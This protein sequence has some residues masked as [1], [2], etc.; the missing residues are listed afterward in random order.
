MSS[1]AFP[2]NISATALLR[3][4]PFLFPV[5]FVFAAILGS[6]SVLYAA[7]ALHV[8]AI[9]AENTIGRL[10]SAVPIVPLLRAS[11][12]FEDACLVIWPIA[13]LTALVAALWLLAHAE[14]TARQVF[15][16]GAIFGYSISIFSAAAGHELL[17]GRS[18]V[19]R[20]CS[21]FLYAA[22]LYPHFPAV[23][24]ASHHRWAGST[25]DCQTPRP[26]QHIH[27][28]LIQALVGGLRTVPRPQAGALD[29]HLYARVLAATVGVTTLGLVGG[30]PAMSFHIVQGLFSFIVVETLNYVQHYKLS[31]VADRQSN[32]AN[33]DLNFVSRCA[34]FNLSLH[35]S[36]HL[37]QN[38]HYSQLS[39]ISGAPSCCWGYWTSFW[40][41]WTPPAWSHLHRLEAE[42]ED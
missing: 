6:I 20:L 12:F 14:P 19:A 2:M 18:R 13:H 9:A 39:P 41:A 1:T 7:V 29:P 27:S 32:L 22:M 30:W 26:G 21:D 15:A 3:L 34:L 10:L 42:K 33:Q 35:A 40:L 25:R 28:Y 36:H 4:L 5:V 37:D 24:L 8:I 16:M 23:H 11:T 17:H 31:G 38:S